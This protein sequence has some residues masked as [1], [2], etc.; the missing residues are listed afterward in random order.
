[1]SVYGP[2]VQYLPLILEDLGQR[3]MTANET[4]KAETGFKLFEHFTARVKGVGFM[5]DK[6]F[7]KGYEQ[8]L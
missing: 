1:M 3:F 5:R 7:R 4:I 6:L 2:D 8:I